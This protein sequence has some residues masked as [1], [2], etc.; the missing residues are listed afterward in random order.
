MIEKSLISFGMHEVCIWPSTVHDRIVNNFGWSTQL[1][2]RNRIRCSIRREKLLLLYSRVF[3]PETG[4]WRLSSFSIPFAHPPRHTF[5]SSWFQVVV[6]GGV[7]Y[8]LDGV[9]KVY[10][11]TSVDPFGVV[12]GFGIKWCLIPL[13]EH[14][15]EINVHMRGFKDKFRL[16]TPQDVPID[17]ERLSNVWAFDLGAEQRWK[18]VGVGPRGW[19]WERCDRELVLRSR[20][21]SER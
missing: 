13:T 3:Y 9:E 17:D 5:L 6:V 11:L 19:S 4:Q 1:Q 2:I 12:D 8:W 15:T 14:L 7:L 16:G 20:L 21:P 10:R 18:L